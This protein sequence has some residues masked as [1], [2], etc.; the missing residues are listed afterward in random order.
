MDNVLITGITELDSYPRCGRPKHC[1]QSIESDILCLPE[2]NLKI[3]SINEVDVNISVEKFEVVN[4]ILGPKLFLKAYKN[5]K[6]I[7]TA[8]NCSQSLHSICWSIPFCEFILLCDFHYEKVCN[9][10]CDV[11]IGIENI[12]IKDFDEEMVDISIM[13]IMCPQFKRDPVRDCKN[14]SDCRKSCYNYRRTLYN[15]R[16]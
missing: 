4:T 11:F 2:N 15:T 13:F 3:E 6:V 10:I 16:F 9:L 7:Y 1:K 12:C 14:E 5:I 8:D